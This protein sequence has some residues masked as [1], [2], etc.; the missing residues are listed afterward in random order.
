MTGCGSPATTMATP[1]WPLAVG[2]GPNGWSAGYAFATRLKRRRA[3]RGQRPLPPQGARPP[4]R[5]VGRRALFSG[6]W[7]AANPAGAGR[8]HR[9]PGRHRTCF[10][11]F[12]PQRF[13]R[14]YPDPRPHS[15]G[16]ARTLGTAFAAPSLKPLAAA[17]ASYIGGMTLIFP[18]TR[19]PCFG[20][21]AT[22]AWPIIPA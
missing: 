8:V 12:F 6:R 7:K 9:R 13:H 22:F 4:P 15:V 20:S 11:A 2:R 18:P 17:V 3:W 19:R 10:R 16:A 21:A 1:V 14:P 5:P